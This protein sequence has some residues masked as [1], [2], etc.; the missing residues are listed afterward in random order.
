MN[1]FNIVH[2]DKTMQILTI[3]WQAWGYE[4]AQ[5]RKQQYIKNTSTKLDK[6]IKSYYINAFSKLNAFNYLTQEIRKHYLISLI[7]ISKNFIKDLEHFST[8]YLK[9]RHSVFNPVNYKPINKFNIYLRIKSHIFQHFDT[10]PKQFN[11]NSVLRV[12]AI[13]CLF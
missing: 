8:Y 9:E 13:V 12:D 3:Y 4:Q 2:Q 10:N 7:P 1:N 6:L 5:L 11:I